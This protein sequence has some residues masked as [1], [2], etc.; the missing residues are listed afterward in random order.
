MAT[1][2]GARGEERYGNYQMKKLLL[3]L[4]GTVILLVVVFLS[5]GFLYPTQMTET[6][7]TINKPREAVWAYFTDQSKLKDWLPN[8]KSIENMSG[9][10]MTKGSKFRMTFVE[11]GR[12]IVMTET[13]TEVKSNEVFAFVLENEVITANVKV[14]F[15]GNGDKTDVTEQNTFVG[16]NL[17]WRSLFAVM[18]ASFQKQAMENYQKLKTNIERSQ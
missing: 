11:N 9:E 7:V 2:G 6:R 13:M 18:K 16:G 5:F 4:F 14:M 8:V 1:L 12:E 10:P 15:T 3:G 17:F